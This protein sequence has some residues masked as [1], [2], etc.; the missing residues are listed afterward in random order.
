MLQEAG[1]FEAIQR[2][3][4]LF[5][6]NLLEANNRRLLW[7]DQ[8]LR[9]IAV[10]IDNI[11]H[12]LAWSLA[13]EQDNAIGMELAAAS[14]PLWIKLSLLSEAADWMTLAIARPSYAATLHQSEEEAGE[15]AIQR[16]G[17][18][19]ETRKSVP[20]T[21]AQGR[22]LP[23]SVNEITDLANKARGKSNDV[24]E[25]SEAVSTELAALCGRL[26]ATLT[27]RNDIEELAG[28][29]VDMPSHLVWP[30]QR[31]AGRVIHISPRGAHL[32]VD[33][34]RV[35][36]P[37]R[38]ALELEWPGA[39][40]GTVRG[41]A[42][43]LIAFR[44]DQADSDTTALLAKMID[45]LDILELWAFPVAAE[46]ARKVTDAFTAALDEGAIKMADLFDEDYQPIPGT[47]PV[48]HL[49]RFTGF[50]ERVLPPIQEPA[51]TI[52]A[53]IVAVCATDRN[54]YVPMNNLYCSKPQGPDPVWNLANC[55]NRTLLPPL[56]PSTAVKL[57][58]MATDEKERYGI[59]S[60]V[61][62]VS[63]GKLCMLR[64]VAM[65]VRV[66]GRYWGALN[67]TYYL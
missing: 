44:F 24:E 51:L 28:L 5:F 53:R 7:D 17:A 37:R 25:R 48:Q 26:S 8:T 6:R 50:C 4:A 29:P 59:W 10:D 58:K 39:I 31:L 3:H 34:P 12:A 41:G 36:L 42:N 63:T 11:R 66:R 16:D 1:E 46:T 43:G 60:Y 49:V 20:P 56:P 45:S 14:S 15:T 18:A 52:D 67:V 35:P 65:P 30:G 9:L 27:A 19:L 21:S 32:R 61:R 38:A 22:G 62:E 47:N 13:N 33:E 40:S 54:G 64:N 57:A 2:R 55:R 23:T